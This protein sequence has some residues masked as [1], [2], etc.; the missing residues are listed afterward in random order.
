MWKKD[1]L[2]LI[3]VIKVTLCFQ[4]SLVFA[5]WYC[6]RDYDG[7]SVTPDVG[8][9]V[10]DEETIFSITEGHLDSGLRGI[11]VG[12]CQTSYVEIGRASCRERV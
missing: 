5:R 3:L 10:S 12:T 11:P 6:R 9:H 8:A 4:I 7:V 2:D 1:R